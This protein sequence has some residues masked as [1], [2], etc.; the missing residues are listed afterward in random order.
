MIAKNKTLPINMLIKPASGLCDMRCS[1][2][3]Y[4]DETEKR[5]VKSYGMMS[6]ETLENL[7]RK[8]LEQG[9]SPCTFAFQGGEPTLI[10]LDFYK[11]FVELV[12]KHKPEN[13]E[14]YFAIQTNGL[15]INDEWA[16][17][18]AEN[19]FLVGLSMDGNKK[20]HD[21]LRFDAKQE[22]T[23]NRVLRAS[24]ILNNH[25][26]EY[27]ILTV[28]TSN[29]AKNIKD[30][31]AFFERNNFTYQQYIPCLDP[32]GEDRGKYEWSLTPQ[33]YAQFLKTLFDLWYRSFKRDKPVS[34]RYFDNL[35]MLL[36]GQPPESCGMMG[37][38]TFQNV[39][40]ADGGVY[41]CDFYALDEYNIGS[42][43]ENSFEEIN[44]K[45]KEIGFIETSQYV[46]EDCKACKW[47]PLCRGGCRRDRDNFT[48]SQLEKN[49]F[50]PAFKQ[51]FEYS[52]ERL[53]EVAQT[54]MNRQ[55]GR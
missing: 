6:E 38:C 19:N 5:E 29:V 18:F 34:I 45:R 14:T 37:N 44:Q 50:C 30:M 26:V 55:R 2:C 42:I 39:I 53:E 36:L 32:I 7:V 25:K 46:D 28:I 54:V 10:G 33:L 24:Q 40:E 9:F 47:Y 35:V 51:F 43:N 52:I 20:V 41:P 31:Y 13:T 27:N 22:G 16:Q 48:G 1:Y 15:S 23:F 49:Y 4:C 3:F 21:S 8:P 12:K 17:F 11:K